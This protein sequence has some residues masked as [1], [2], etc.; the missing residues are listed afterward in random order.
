[1]T[2][3]NWTKKTAKVSTYILSFGLWIWTDLLFKQ[4]ET[5]IHKNKGRKVEYHSEDT[6]KE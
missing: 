1:M 4:E 2:R 5:I 3:P 6:K